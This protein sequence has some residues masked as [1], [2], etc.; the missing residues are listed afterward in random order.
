MK[1]SSEIFSNSNNKSE[2]ILPIHHIYPTFILY[3]PYKYLLYFDAN[4]HRKFEK[5]QQVEILKLS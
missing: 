2:L 5:E 1:V 4:Y 3:I